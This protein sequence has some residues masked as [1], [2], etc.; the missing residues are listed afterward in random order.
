MNGFLNVKALPAS[1]SSVSAVGDG[2]AD[3]TQAIQNAVN[4]LKRADAVPEDCLSG[5]ESNRPP[6]RWPLYY[7][8]VYFPAGLYRITAPIVMPYMQQTRLFGDGGRELLNRDGIPTIPG[9]SVIRQDTSDQPIFKFVSGDSLGVSIERLGFTW[10]TQQTPP[11]GWQRTELKA[12]LPSDYTNPGAVGILFSAGGR[13]PAITDDGYYHFRI[14]DCTFARGFRGI[15]I[16]DTYDLGTIPVFATQI[17]H[18][19]FHQLSGAAISLANRPGREIGMTANAIR[20]VFI[21]NYNRVENGNVTYFSENF[22]SQIQ[23]VAQGCCTLDGIDAEGS[24]TRVLSAVDCVLE[25][26]NLYLEP[27]EVQG[28]Y[29]TLIFFGGGR[30]A[31]HGMNLDGLMYAENDPGLPDEGPSFSTIVN[32][33]GADVVVSGIRVNPFSGKFDQNGNP[34]SNTD[35]RRDVGGGFL[36]L[37]GPAY[38]VS[39]AEATYRLLDRPAAPVYPQAARGTV[40]YEPKGGGTLDLPYRELGTYTDGWGQPMTAAVRAPRA[41]TRRQLSFPSIPKQSVGVLRLGECVGPV[42]N[43]PALAALPG[44]APGD[45][46]TLG[47]PN[48]PAGL[49]ASGV[50]IQRG[51]VELR[52]YAARRSRRAARA[53]TGA[54]GGVA[55][56]GRARRHGGRVASLGRRNMASGVPAGPAGERVRGRRLGRRAGARRGRGGVRG[57]L[58]RRQRLRLPAGGG[59]PADGRLV[60]ARRGA[61]KRAGGSLGVVAGGVGVGRRGGRGGGRRPGVGPA[62]GGGVPAGA[63]GGAVGRGG[64]PG[65]ARAAGGAPVRGGGRCRHGVGRGRSGC[66]WARRARRQRVRAGAPTCSGAAAAESGPRRQR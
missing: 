53:A 15:A 44:A 57:D 13:L 45:L 20:D 66:W 21:E 51:C 14:T 43:N 47:P 61:R 54:A 18:C 6:K 23:L 7:A 16:D 2:C 38:L 1:V 39:G 22:E 11:S 9:G 8:G 10:R 42:T 46:V 49:V 33:G 41:K 63:G 36:P 19:T 27:V 28:L 59:Q 64:A 48:L 30:Y 12:P 62:R 40:T 55:G 56:A 32:A 58:R 25:I 26:T 52:L 35:P 34:I 3:D 31:L 4:V 29:P 17:D 24:K 5:S 65:C 37:N 50:V 60:G